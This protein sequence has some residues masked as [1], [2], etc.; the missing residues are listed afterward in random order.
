MGLIAGWQFKGKYFYLWSYSM[1]K[2]WY[3]SLKLLR[4]KA[5]GRRQKA[6]GR[7]QSRCRRLGRR[8]E[9]SKALR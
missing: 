3:F 8:K 4:G 9:A 2:V 6:E 1:L 5:E 7:R